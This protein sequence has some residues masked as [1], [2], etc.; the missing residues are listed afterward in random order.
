[1]HHLIVLGVGGPV[2]LLFGGLL[3][4]MIFMQR[5]LL[6]KARQAGRTPLRAIA[7]LKPGVAMI[8]GRLVAHDK[9]LSSPLY[10]RKCVYY[11]VLVQ[12]LRTRLNARRRFTQDY[13]TLVDDKCAIDVTVD[14][15]T[16]EA[17]VD[18]KQAEILARC[19]NVTHSDAD[20]NDLLHQ[21]YGLA[22]RGLVLGRNYRV[23]EYYLEEGAKVYVVG[24]V[25]CKQG[26]TPRFH[27]DHANL[28]VSDKDE[29]A[30]A[31]SYTTG[32]VLHWI[33]IGLCC[34]VVLGACFATALFELVFTTAFALADGLLPPGG[35]PQPQQENGKYAPGKPIRDAFDDQG[36]A[37]LSELQESD[38][39]VGWGKFGKRGMLGYGVPIGREDSEITV[40]GKTAP[41][42]I[43]MVPVDNAFS[44]VKYRLDGRARK[45]E[46]SAGLNDMLPGEPQP[47]TEATFKVLGDG[48]E[49]WASRPNNTP[50]T[51]E[52]FRID[53]QGIDWLEL[54]VDCP[55]RMNC[56]RA[57]WLEPRVSR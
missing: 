44:T 31:R 26:L 27:G 35:G 4:F 15:G 51:S 54:R 7:D 16:G 13:A 39:R 40:A 24:D 36:V 19:A 8:R 29:N 10:E 9:L 34:L 12:E 20:I 57:V 38:A 49:L 6:A 30:F 22:T 43:S 18:L 55:G 2:I 23:A 56:V 41:H 46:G 48:R 28:I 25:D 53:V 11:R 50:G 1:M 3:G 37:Y 47:F 45:L 14:D 17:E 21:R 5:R 52:A 33:G 42:G 32:I